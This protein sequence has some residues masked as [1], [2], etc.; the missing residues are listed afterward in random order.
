MEQI[1]DYTDKVPSASKQPIA[2]VNAHTGGRLPCCLDGGP[3]VVFALA[4]S[5]FRR[6]A[7]RET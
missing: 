7:P 2:E 5:K 4:G 1:R 3:Q 6:S